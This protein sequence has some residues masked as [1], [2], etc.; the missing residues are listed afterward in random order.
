MHCNQVTGITNVIQHWDLTTGIPLLGELY[1]RAPA[2]QEALLESIEQCTRDKPA[3]AIDATVEAVLAECLY[4]VALC[5]ELQDLQAFVKAAAKG[6]GVGLVEVW[7]QLAAQL[8]RPQE[9][10]DSIYGQ[11][12]RSHKPARLDKRGQV[13]GFITSFLDG[14]FMLLV[15]GPSYGP[16]PTFDDY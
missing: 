8:N 15:L 6:A 16:A 13:A 4:P 12:T 1:K 10:E 14:S 2:L 11:F 3:I 5:L 9:G 7:K